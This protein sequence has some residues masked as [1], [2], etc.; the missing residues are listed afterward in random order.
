MVGLERFSE[1]VLEYLKPIAIWSDIAWYNI[2]NF[3]LGC[4]PAFTIV[5]ILGYAVVTCIMLSNID[6]KA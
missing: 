6:F 5:Y 3:L 4:L 1:S 2:G